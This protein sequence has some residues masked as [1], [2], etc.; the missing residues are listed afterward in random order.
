MENS[1]LSEFS[2]SA[3]MATASTGAVFELFR[4]DDEECQEKLW[5]VFLLSGLIFPLTILLILGIWR[6]ISHIIHLRKPRGYRPVRLAPPNFR[7]RTRNGSF[8]THSGNIV[9]VTVTNPEGETSAALKPGSPEPV[10]PPRVHWLA[11]VQK[12]ASEIVSAQSLTGKIAVFITF[13][14]SMVSL[15]LYFLE[16]TNSHIEM[17]Q[18]KCADWSQRIDWQ[19]ELICSVYLLID[20]FIRFIAAHNKVRFMFEIYSIVDYLTIPPA[21]LVVVLDHHWTGLRFLRAL[22]VL[23]IPDIL[24]FCNVLRTSTSIRLAQLLSFLTSVILV[25]AGFFH[26][27]ETYGDFHLDQRNP[28][29][30]SYWEF[31]YFTV[32][33]M[34]TVGYGDIFPTTRLGKAFGSVFIIF[35]FTVFAAFVPEMFRLFQSRKRYSDPYK[36]GRGI[37]HVIAAGDI[38]TESMQRFLQVFYC[39][40][41]GKVE[42]KVVFVNRTDPDLE[43]EA[44]LKRNATRAFYI[45]G[46]VLDPA[47]LQR[48]AIDKA[49]ACLILADKNASN[50][51]AE[52]AGSVM[53]VIAVKNVSPMTRCLVQLLHSRSI[54][55]VMNIPGFNALAGDSVICFSTLEL[56]LLAQSCLAPGFATLICNL[57]NANCEKVDHENGVFTDYVEASRNKIFMEELGS[58]FDGM[59]FLEASRVCHLKLEVLLIGLLEADQ[60]HPSG[61]VLL[62]PSVNIRPGR[63]G[64]FIAKTAEEVCKAWFLCKQCHSDVSPKQKITFC[65]CPSRIPSYLQTAARDPAERFRTFASSLEGGDSLKDQ[66]LPKGWE[67]TILK[68]IQR[69]P[70]SVSLHRMENSFSDLKN[71]PL[72]SLQEEQDSDSMPLMASISPTSDESDESPHV[73]DVTRAFYSCTGKPYK[74]VIM[75]RSKAAKQTFND[76]IVVLVLAG[77]NDP[78]VGFQDFILPLR[79]SKIRYDNLKEIV[80]LGDAQFLEKEWHK[81][82]N[83]PKLT[84]VKGDPLDRADLRAVSIKTCA[85]CVILPSRSGG[86]SDPI[87][88]DKDAILATLNIMAMNFERVDAPPRSRSTSTQNA[89][90]SF[91]KL[92]REGFEVPTISALYQDV[93]VPLLEAFQSDKSVFKDVMLM[94]P[95]VCGYALPL[96]ALDSILIAN[97]FNPYAI[98]LI[99]ALLFGDMSM[100]TETLLAEGIGLVSGEMPAT[101]PGRSGNSQLRLVSLWD[102]PLR[103]RIPGNSTYGLLFTE[104]CSL[105]MICLGLCR[106]VYPGTW[107][108]RATKRSVIT[109]PPPEYE[110]RFDDLV[111]VLSS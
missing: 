6:A 86:S 80:F 93:N 32:V 87:L 81:I 92:A 8:F 2:S 62:N 100:L 102:H 66:T 110:L 65:G 20:F 9:D 41:R 18:E 64:V 76:H 103:N 54:S 36:P 97:F 101:D 30:R 23:S 75:N 89:N 67:R 107:G 46:S 71:R 56:G 40:Q 11:V 61:T 35:A 85:M 68:L 19:L 58:Y 51:T 95:Y 82:R 73:L 33:S 74:S 70:S 88:D 50:P 52:D 91:K 79:S 72:E 15:V 96:S 21:F 63:I 1:T 43:M 4:Y 78:P 90:F 37:R 59:S 14:V 57:M 3:E 28:V 22:Y 55:H 29:L 48:A 105:G 49:L 38:S 53:S 84:I 60:N 34:S 94:E 111:Y 16:V 47:D 42:L 83:L 24:Q 10:K 45:Q 31:V 104:A 106:R 109:N 108:S 98:E 27:F 44:L 77:P 25:S 26:L 7:D 17:I 5:W 69:N 13:I 39:K 99:K 12:A